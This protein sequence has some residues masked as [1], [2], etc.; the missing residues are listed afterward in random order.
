MRGAL[1]AVLSIGNDLELLGYRELVLRLAGC[2]VRS[3]AP[4]EA[5]LLL[6]NSAYA[7]VVVGHT[8]RL[9]EQEALATLVRR[10]Y[11]ETKLVVLVSGFWVQFKPGLFDEELHFDY[12]PDRLLAAV[13]RCLR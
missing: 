8:L 6:A 12:G 11:P 5:R 2:A 4:D 7:L 1:P 13:R 10:E 9:D 3:A